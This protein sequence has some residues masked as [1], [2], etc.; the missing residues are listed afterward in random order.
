VE[1][2]LDGDVSGGARE[3]A[4]GRFEAEGATTPVFL[5]GTRAAGV[6]I[7][8]TAAD[9]VVIFDPDWNPQVWFSLF[10]LRFFFGRHL[11]SGLEPTGWFSRLFFTFVF[12]VFFF[13]RHLRSGLEPTGFV[14]TL[15]FY[16]CFLRFGGEPFPCTHGGG[17]SASWLKTWR[18]SHQ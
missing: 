17:S 2:R 1:Q 18:I 7:T 9:T 3:A 6:G 12:Y 8:L 5:L 11:R 10:F 15:V 14:F 4:I 16:V 13:V